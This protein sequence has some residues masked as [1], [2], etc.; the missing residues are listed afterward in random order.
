[1]TDP[2]LIL[3]TDPAYSVAHI[4]GVVEAVAAALPPGALMVQLRNKTSI[5]PVVREQAKQLCEATKRAG[6]LFALNVIRPN[7]DQ[8]IDL[9]E[10]IE[11]DALHVP[12]TFESLIAGRD[13]AKWVSTPV[14]SEVDTKTA[15]RGRAHGTLISP[16]YASPGKGKPRG[17]AAIMEATSWNRS[18]IYALGGVAPRHAPM[19]AQAGA[20]GVAVIRALLDAE[21]PAAVARALAAPFI[22]V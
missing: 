10:E 9:F 20:H 21:D 19:C 1:M 13:I 11:G 8:L 18:A 16:I 6:A 3:I 22:E 5:F 4:K 12:C 17:L 14:H 7:A 15:W 2:K